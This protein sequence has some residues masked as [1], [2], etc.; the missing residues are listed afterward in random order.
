MKLD[1][2]V[3]ALGVGLAAYLLVQGNT[4]FAARR[5]RRRALL[6]LDALDARHQQGGNNEEGS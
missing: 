5:E 6:A 4:W 2:V 1:G 3:V